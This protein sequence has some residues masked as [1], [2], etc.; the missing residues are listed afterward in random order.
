MAGGNLG[1]LDYTSYDEYSADIKARYKLDSSQTLSLAWQHHKQ[2]DVQL[3]HKLITGEYSTYEFDPQQRD[4]FNGFRST[5]SM[6]QSDETRKKQKTGSE[7]FFT[8]HD[9]VRSY[10]LTFEGM[11]VLDGIWE[12]VTGCEAYYDRVSS[13]ALKTNLI[14]GTDSTTPC[15]TLTSRCQ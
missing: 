15:G 1:E 9:L 6:H 2:N 14:S 11:T 8:E 12:G 4:L 5:V 7:D 10:G 3:Y 13:S